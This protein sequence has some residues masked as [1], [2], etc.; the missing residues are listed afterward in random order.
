MGNRPGFLEGYWDYI[1]ANEHVAGGFVWEF[2]NHGFYVEDENG[3]PYTLY[4]GDFGEYCHWANFILDGLLLSDGTHM[5][6]WYEL[7]EVSS[8]IYAK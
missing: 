1:Y 4:G 5:P 3:T 2:K 6:A 8:P 7:K